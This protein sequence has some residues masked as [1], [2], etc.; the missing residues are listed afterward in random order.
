MLALLALR[1]AHFVNA[2]G[3]FAMGI[4]IFFL[5]IPIPQAANFPSLK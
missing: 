1:L 4:R 2:F 3:N 5:P